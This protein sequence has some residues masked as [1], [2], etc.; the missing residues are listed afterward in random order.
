MRKALTIGL[1]AS[2]LM[3]SGCATLNQQTANFLAQV[4]SFTAQACKFIPTIDTILAIFNAGIAT[5]VGTIATTVCAAVPPV[6]T[7]RYRALPRAGTGAPAMAV[8][9]VRSQIGNVVINGWRT[10]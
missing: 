10:Q 6:A 9:S 5:T 1:L 4:Q 8:G 7:V 2:Y 3:V